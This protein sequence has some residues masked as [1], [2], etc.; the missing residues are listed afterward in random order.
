MTSHAVT[1]RASARL[2]RLATVSLLAVA[3]AAVTGHGAL[4]LLAAPALAALAVTSR[5]GAPAELELEAAVAVSRC[6]EGEDI[7]LTVSLASPRILDEITFSLEPPA[8][9]AVVSGQATQVTAGSARAGARWVLQPAAWGRRTPG[10]I[11]VRC[12][13]GGIRQAD[14]DMRAGTVEVFPHPPAAQARLVPAD[15]LRR[16]GEHRARTPGQGI[17]FAGIRDYAVGD[18]S[19]T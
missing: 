1:W 19:G 6:F 4:L 12:R 13:Y 16:I 3:A 5:R 15:L 14:L 11:R 9:F 7:E 10:L 17:E 2:P 18:G 8:T